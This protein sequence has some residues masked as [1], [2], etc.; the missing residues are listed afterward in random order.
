[1]GKSFLKTGIYR[2]YKGNLYEV[3]GVAH[4]CET[5]NPVVIYQA[6]YGSKEFEAYTLWVRSLGSFLEI[7]TIEG[8]VHPRFEF[9]SESSIPSELQ[10]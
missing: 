1:V 3:L 4:D 7:V 10:H 2:H 9:V 6:L 8:K 5:T